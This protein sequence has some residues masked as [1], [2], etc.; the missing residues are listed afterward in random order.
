MKIMI[1][2]SLALCVGV[3]AERPIR[4][5]IHNSAAKDSVIL[6]RGTFIDSRDGKNYKTIRIG[7][8][9]WMAENL[10][11]VTANSW[12]YAN[13]ASKCAKWGRLYV[14]QAARSA[15]PSGW[16][17]P[18]DE[19][20]SVLDSIPAKGLRTQS[21][22]GTNVTGFDALP[23]GYRYRDG[24]FYNGGELAFFW[25][26]SDD[27]VPGAWG[28]ELVA[29]RK[30]L[31]RM[32]YHKPGGFSVRCLKDRPERDLKA[33]EALSCAPELLVH[34]IGEWDR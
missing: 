11:Y 25:S 10:N 6:E 27:V 9:V 22:N 33:I 26:S 34:P 8:Q 4:P 23:G 13:K 20:W 24:S 18:S 12:C 31:I 30:S 17:L 7:S 16:H 19:E 15:C 3:A 29:A 5:L 1:S 21:W 2:I 28:R 32:G 14:W